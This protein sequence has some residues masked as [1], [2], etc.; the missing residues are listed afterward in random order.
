MSSRKKNP[1]SE[2]MIYAL[3]TTVGIVAG[4]VIATYLVEMMRANGAMPTQA[5]PPAPPSPAIQP[6]LSLES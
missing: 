2:A 6:P 1:L 4:T 5:L 3:G